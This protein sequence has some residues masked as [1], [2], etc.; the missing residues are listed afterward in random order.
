MPVTSPAYAHL[1]AV[2]PGLRVTEREP[3]SG[4]GWVTS[5]DL[6]AGGAALDAFTARDAEEITTEAVDT[7][8]SAVRAQSVMLGVDYEIRRN[9]VL[10]A[11]GSYENDKFI[12]QD[13]RDNV[14]SATANLQYLF[15]RFSSVGLRYKYVNRASTVSAATYDKHEIGLDVTA[16]F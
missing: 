1:A 16:H 15:N 12:G 13:R 5:A 14:Y 11:L 9:V 7:I 4:A 6:A 10:S 8:T 3:R 2:F